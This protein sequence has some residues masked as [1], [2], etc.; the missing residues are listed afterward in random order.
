LSL[1]ENNPEEALGF[2]RTVLENEPD[3]EI[4]KK[5][6]EFLSKK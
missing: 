5:Y 1:K 4:A 6:I 3:D 2:F